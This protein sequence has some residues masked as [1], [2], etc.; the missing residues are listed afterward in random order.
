LYPGL[1]VNTEKTKH[2]LL[3]RHQN[4]G[5]NFDKKI[6]NKSFGNVAQLKYLET[7]ITNQNLSQEEI[8]RRINMNND[9]Y[10]SVQKPL[11]SRLLDQGAIT[12]VLL[13]EKYNVT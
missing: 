7:N 12:D 5:Q 4:A 13:W 10:H 9:C 3:P 11:S 1:E 6:A 8:T 2:I